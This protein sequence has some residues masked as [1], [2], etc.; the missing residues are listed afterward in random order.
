M[1]GV[2]EGVDRVSAPRDG[3]RTWQVLVTPDKPTA[4]AG[5]DGKA[6]TTIAFLI[7]REPDPS[8]Q[9]WARAPLGTGDRVQLPLLTGDGAV[10]VARGDGSRA[11]VPM[12]GWAFDPAA[13]LT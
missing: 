3:A 11:V 12:I 9:T 5:G 7:P 1:S 6:L 2:V 10:L 8:A 4:L 13:P